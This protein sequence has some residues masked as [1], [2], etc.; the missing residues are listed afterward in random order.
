MGDT[1]LT[2]GWQEPESDGGA[3]IVEY[4]VERRNVGKKAWQKVGRE[5]ELSAKLHLSKGRWCLVIH[6]GDD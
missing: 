6:S 4:L 5:W 1:S 2:L 3:A